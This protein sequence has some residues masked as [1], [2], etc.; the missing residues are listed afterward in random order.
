[1]ND[2]EKIVLTTVLKKIKSAKRHPSVRF[3][4]AVY[5]PQA[6]ALRAGIASAILDRSVTKSAKEAQY[7]RLR[8]ALLTLTGAEGNCIAALDADFEAKAKALLAEEPV[9]K[10]AWDE[11]L[12]RCS[13]GDVA[14]HTHRD[15]RP[16]CGGMMCCPAANE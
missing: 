12:I 15:K 2:R 13:C 7:G 11:G 16:C 8:L 4:D 14:E 1:M 6:A 3:L 5:G 10:D 9:K